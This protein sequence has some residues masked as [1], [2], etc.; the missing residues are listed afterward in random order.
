MYS[1]E[2]AVDKLNHARS[3]D[4][5]KPVQNNTRLYE[6]EDGI[7]VKFHAVDVVTIHPDGT[8]TLR[9]GGW[10]TVTTLERIR[11][12]SP[13]K[14]VSVNQDRGGRGDWYVQLEPNPDDPKPEYV[15]RPIPAPFTEPNPGPKPENPWLGDWWERNR[16]YQQCMDLLDTYGSLE[17]WKAER[18]IQYRARRDYL[19]AEREWWT[20]NYIPFYDGIKVDSEGYAPR[21]RADGPSPAK[22]RRYEAAVKQMK[23]RIDKY[24]KEYIDALR[25]GMPMPGSGDCW[26]CA[27]TAENGQPLGDA[28][29]N[30]DHLINHMEDDYY[31][32]SLAVNA[33]REAGYSDTGIYIFLNIKPEQGTMGGHANHFDNRIVKKSIVSYMR[34]RLLPQAP[35]E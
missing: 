22:L 8:Y 30:H 4:A 26:F 29:G 12:F 24:A 2:W 18:K 33:I 9:N 13:A 16:R 28:T 23:A 5:G 19:K 3:K 1:Y 21:L 14:L 31:V 17:G 35:T 6:R 10:N 7:A 27:M 11:D 20:R 15:N 34:K 25:E 32:P